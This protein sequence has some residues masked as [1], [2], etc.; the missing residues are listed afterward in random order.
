MPVVWRTQRGS[1]GQSARKSYTAQRPTIHPAAAPKRTPVTRIGAYALV[2]M[3]SGTLV[4][5]PTTM[6]LITA[7]NGKRTVA[8]KNPSANRDENAPSSADR[9]S[10]NLAG[11][12]TERPRPQSLDQG[13]RPASRGSCHTPSLLNGSCEVYVIGRFRTHA[14]RPRIVIEPFAF[15]SGSF[16]GPSLGPTPAFPQSCS[17]RGH[18]SRCPP[19][20]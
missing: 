2:M 8:A 5:I 13:P 19:P 12:S 1:A 7:G 3:A 6:P 4:K 20:T 18:D 11:A 14:G 10:G 15:L 17:T 16:A 9:L